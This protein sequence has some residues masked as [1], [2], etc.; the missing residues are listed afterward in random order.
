MGP[1]PDELPSLTD[2]YFLK[3]REVVRQFGDCEVTYAVIMRRPVVFTPKLA[4]DWL[5][6]MAAARDGV[7]GLTFVPDRCLDPFFA[8]VVQA[9]DEAIVGSLVA[10]QD[11]TG[12]DGHFVPALPH[13]ALLAL[14]R[15]GSGPA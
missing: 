5:L 8:A 14:L 11:M 3:T 10:N 15:S 12:R 13:A 7:A 4:V 9:I 6:E 2:K 1:A